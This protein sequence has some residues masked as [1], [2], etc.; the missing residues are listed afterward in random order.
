M[1]SG[2]REIAVITVPQHQHLV[3][4]VLG[5]GSQWGID[6]SYIGQ[7]S[8]DGLA[9]AYILVKDYLAGSCSV[10]ILGDNLFFGH[11]LRFR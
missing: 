8:P 6:L 11:S 2:V 9:Q 5:D 7:L 4:R 1:L 10:M 3:E